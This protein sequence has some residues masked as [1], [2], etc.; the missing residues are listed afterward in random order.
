MICSKLQVK[1]EINNLLTSNTGEMYTS[2]NQRTNLTPGSNRTR[3]DQSS[4]FPV[5]ETRTEVK[6][7]INQLK[8]NV[9]AC[10]D[11]LKPLSIKHVSL[12]IS[13]PLC[14]IINNILESG[15]FPDKL[16]IAKVSPIYKGSG[17]HDIDNYRSISILPM[18]SKALEC[19][20]NSRL[21]QFF[22]KFNVMTDMQYGFRK[23]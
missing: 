17:R 16:K 20:I 18:F 5:S 12:H 3:V 7:L 23:Q 15:I 11:E 8:N 22:Y 6:N 2:I 14:H 10:A 13:A 9:A 19:V 21:T 4:S 1:N